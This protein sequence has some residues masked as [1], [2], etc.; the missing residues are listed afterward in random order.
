MSG[1]LPRAALVGWDV[2]HLLDLIYVEPEEA[3]EQ[4]SARVGIG[5]P[6]SDVEAKHPSAPG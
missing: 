3:N 1:T 5:T 4:L 2:P 6:L